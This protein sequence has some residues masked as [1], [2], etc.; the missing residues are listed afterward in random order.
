MAPRVEIATAGPV[1]YPDAG[2]ARGWESA[3]LVA[4]TVLLLSFGLL[5]LYSTSSLLAQRSGAPDYVYVLRQASAA[6][7]GLLALVVCAGI[8]YHAWR[9][10]AWP[11]MGASIALLLLIVLPGTE[12]IAPRINGARRWLRVSGV[13]VQPSEIAKFAVIVWTAGMALRKQ[14]HFRSLSKGLMPFLLVWGVLL[15]LTALEPDLST[16][17]L[18]GLLGAIVAFSA[19][20][21][22]AHFAFLGLLATPVVIAQLGVGF[23]GDRIRAWIDPMAD[24]AGAGFQIKQSLISIGSGGLT[25]EGFAQGRQKFGFLPEPHTDFMFSMIGEEWGFLGVAGLVLLYLSIVL[26]GFRIARR[27]PD[28]F[29]ELLAI[30]FSSLIAVHALLHMFV[31]LA[32]APTTG[33]PLPL[34]SYGRSNLVVTLAAVG[35]LMSVARAASRAERRGGRSRAR[36]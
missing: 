1:R 21:R 7:A 26:V 11:L 20:A 29:G 17:A 3:A 6:A 4:V 22:L 2:L 34:I 16:A 10:L 25:G 23:R 8:P 19:G 14:E 33:L 31:G 35:V 15:V 36:A 5:T 9:R 28:L 12:A 24:P 13:S 18:I 32:L 27:A 30:G